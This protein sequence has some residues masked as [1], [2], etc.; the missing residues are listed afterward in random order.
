MDL[1]PILA[2]STAAL[3]VLSASFFLRIRDMEHKLH[4]VGLALYQLNQTLREAHAAFEE[5]A[6]QEA[7]GQTTQQP[8][9][10]KH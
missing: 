10:T 6:K 5:A 3:A 2:G 8:M 9:E 4:T 7:S 1:V